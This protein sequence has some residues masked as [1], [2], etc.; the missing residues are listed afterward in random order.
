MQRVEV[1]VIGSGL[2]GLTTAYLLTQSGFQVTL[3]EKHEQIGF[4]CQSIDV[5]VELSGKK[6]V[7]RVDTPMRSFSG[8]FYKNLLKLYEHL[9][10]PLRQQQYTYSFCA[11]D[12]KGMHTHFN[13]RGGLAGFRTTM[14]SFVVVF[15]F[16][17]Y[18]VLAL[19]LHYSGATKTVTFQKIS[20]A[21]FCRYTMLPDSFRKYLLDPLFQCVCTCDAEQ[22]ANYP[23][24]YLLDYR[25]STLFQP[26]YTTNLQ[27]VVEKLSSSVHRICLGATIEVDYA[28]HTIRTATEKH[29]YPY[30][31]IAYAD[32]DRLRSDISVI[33]HRVNQK[34]LSNYPAQLNVRSFKRGQFMANHM[35]SREH[36][37]CQTT[38]PT[39]F[40]SFVQQTLA[41][42]RFQRAIKSTKVAEPKLL[43]ADG[44]SLSNKNGL[45]NIFHVG[46]HVFHGIPLLEGCVHSA[47]LV[48]AEIVRR[49]GL[50]ANFVDEVFS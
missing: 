35:V 33:T 16:F 26:H 42:S 32:K 22:L 39:Q 31:I 8:G 40:E 36:A 49:E 30:I 14:T 4:D 29:R 25:A 46:S 27:L 23:A 19:V 1:A 10:V 47:R 43:T 18:T 44:S 21:Q 48:A 7:L 45:D 12:A 41:I 13:G 9:Q 38:I 50:Q 17:W 20:H 24:A 5:D 2:A 28:S 37:I 6:Q 15:A 11:D 34:L 3:F